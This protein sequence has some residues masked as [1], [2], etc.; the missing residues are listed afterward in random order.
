MGGVIYVFIYLI[1][2]LSFQTEWIIALDKQ[3][4]NYVCQTRC[5]LVYHHFAT[6]HRTT[7]F[8][9]PNLLVVNS[10][11]IREKTFFFSKL[12]RQRRWWLLMSCFSI[13]FWLNKFQLQYLICLIEFKNK[14]LFF[15]LVNAQNLIPISNWYFKPL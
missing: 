4:I 11:K 10:D 3:S 2:Y 12:L 15:F 1:H 14:F 13:L 9:L 5:N 8:R 6:R 7:L